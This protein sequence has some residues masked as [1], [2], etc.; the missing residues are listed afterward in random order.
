MEKRKSRRIPVSI[1]VRYRREGVFDKK[2]SEAFAENM[3]EGG[4]LLM[5]VEEPVAIGNVLELEFITFRQPNPINAKARIV[6][7]KELKANKTYEAGVTFTEI[8]E[9]DLS[10]IRQWLQAVD[11]D[12][13][14]SIA[15]RN[16]ASD[17]HLV[18]GRP[19]TMRVFGDLRPITPQELTAEDVRSMVYGMLSSEQRERFERDLEL[20]VSYCNDVG[21]FRLNVH[22]EKGQIGAS[23]RYIPTDIPTLEQLH[24]PS[25][26]EELAKKPTGLVLVTGPNGSGKSTTLAAMI[27]IINNTRKCVVMS[28]EE[29]IEYLFRPKKS[30]IEQREIGIDAHSFQSALKYIVRQ[31]ID[32]LFIGEIRDL[33]SISVALSAAETGH[34]VLTTLHTM[35]AV[36]SINRIVD[37]FPANQQQQIRMQL[38]ETLRGVVCQVLLPRA[39][40]QGRIVATEVLIVTPAVANMIR[41]G[42]TEEIKGVIETGSRLGMHTMEQSLEELYT[43]GLVSRESILSYTTNPAKYL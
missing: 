42:K 7:V 31:D 19:P 35:D 2:I 41:K 21:R 3:G 29:P 8:R 1:K 43:K 9:K 24:L 10:L 37:A 16:Q 38:A 33:N 26:L 40:K 25:I 12:R 36:S 17:V 4:M 27:E 32:V 6:W 14:L 30:I 34:L 13:L 39:D 15:V 5:F 18:V 22:Q 23:M 11:I 20:D 28:L